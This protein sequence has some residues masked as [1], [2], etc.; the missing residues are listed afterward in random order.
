V[1]AGN[2]KVKINA[3]QGKLQDGA[4][5]MGVTLAPSPIPFMETAAKVKMEGGFKYYITLQEP[6]SRQSV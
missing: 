6:F 1:D 5:L 2:L 3:E 4:V